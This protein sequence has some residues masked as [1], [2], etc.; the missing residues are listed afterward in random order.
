LLEGSGEKTL[1]NLL[2]AN[3]FA[4]VG[5]GYDLLAKNWGLRTWS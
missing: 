4:S 5:E 3:A 2:S 1:N